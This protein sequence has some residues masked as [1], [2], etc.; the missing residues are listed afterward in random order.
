[1]AK[2]VLKSWHEGYGQ[3]NEE[4][5]NGLFKSITE[6]GVGVEGEWATFTP[7][8]HLLFLMY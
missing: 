8:S 1:M 2:L 6:E 3:D 4:E 5:D 7:V